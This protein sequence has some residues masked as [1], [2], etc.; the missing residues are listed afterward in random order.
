M[1]EDLYDFDV[2]VDRRFVHGCSPGVIG[3]RINA[4]QRILEQALKNFD[5]ASASREVQGTIS[6][7]RLGI[8]PAWQLM[9]HVGARDELEALPPRPLSLDAN[10]GLGNFFVAVLDGQDQRS[11]SG[12]NKEITDGRTAKCRK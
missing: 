6:C 2:A 4:G 12:N 5:A 10:Q 9:A 3:Q 8:R 7:P 11:F 1:D